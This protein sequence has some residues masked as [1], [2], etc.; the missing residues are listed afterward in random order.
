MN[1]SFVYTLF[2]SL[3]L[4][5]NQIQYQELI[6][7]WQLVDFDGIKKIKSSPQYLSSSADFRA[8]LETKINYRLENT[9]YKFTEGDSLAYTDFVNNE[10]VL[11]KAKIELNEDN[12]LTIHEGENVKQAKILE[13]NGDN[14]ILEPISTNGNSA[15]K[16]VFERIVVKKEK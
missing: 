1:L 7:S 8:N 10:I 4:G 12:I 5:W 13:F 2:L 11:K 6:G 16:L 14:L 3:V 9:V 15:G